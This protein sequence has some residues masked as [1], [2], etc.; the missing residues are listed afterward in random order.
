MKCLAIFLFLFVSIMSFGQNQKEIDSLFWLTRSN[1]F[2]SEIQFKEII[3]KSD[4]GL[5]AWENIDVFYEDEFGIMWCLIDDGLYRYNGHSAIN[6]NNYLS[7]FY[8][9]NVGEQAGTIF[10]IGRNNII[11]YGERKGLYKIDLKNRTSQKIV[12]DK[13]L[14][15]PNWRN[16]ILHLKEV[17]NTLYVGTS[18][19]LYLIDINT[20]N[21]LKKYLTD[22]IDIHH[23]NSSHGVVSYL[24]DSKNNTLWVAVQDGL[25]KINT[26]NDSIKRY[27]IKDA[28]YIYPH[29]FHDLLPYEN[30]FL[31]PTHGMG[32][33]EFN[34]E[35]G[36]FSHFLTT[37]KKEY[38]RSPNVIR[39]A[40]PLNDSIFLVNA[41]QLGNGLY[42]RYTKN[43][44][45]IETPE[46][47]KDG[48]FFN[49]DRSGYVWACK[50]G[51]IF[52]STQ[53]LIEQNKAYQHIIDI[54]SFVAN[55]V[56]IGSP[57][58]DNYSAIELKENMRNIS[59][60]FSISKPFILDTISYEYTLNENKWI[61]IETPNKLNLFNLSSGE[62]Q[63]T[64]RA[65]NKGGE[66]LTTRKLNFSIFLPFYKSVYFI[67]SIVLLFLTAIYLLFRYTVH[68]KTAKKL[69]ELNQAKSNFFTNISH[70]F[71]TPLTLISG[72]IQ[73]QLS[74]ET[75][76]PTE[77]ENFQ[78]ANRNS[79]RLLSLVDQLLDISKLEAGN[80]N[81]KVDQQPILP[82]IGSLA[83]SFTYITKEKDITY[84]KYINQTEVTTYFDADVLEK[85]LINLLSN[86]V[87]YTPKGGTV[88][89]NASVNNNELQAIIKNTGKGLNKT[90]Q[91]KIFE[92]FYQINENK[93][94]I[95]I[96]LALVKELVI[97]HKGSIT[98]E[99]TPNEWTTFTVKL[100]I[101]KNAFS[102][103][104]M[105]ELTESKPSEIVVLESELNVT[106]SQEEPNIE[107]PDQP[108]LLIVDDNYDIR[109]YV[110]SIFKNNYTILKAKNGQ[111]GIDLAI[112]HIP[113]IIVS[114]VMMPVKNG[115]ELCNT[116]KNDER[117]SHIPIV[118]LT[119]KAGEENEL[120]GI[121][122]GA[123]DYITKPFHEE[124]LKERIKKRIEIRN[125][126]Q[127]RYSQEVI[128]R[129]KD[130]AITPVDEQF[131]ER[132]QKILDTKLIEPSFSIED[133]S[134]ALGMSR[135]QLHRKLKALTGMSAS[136]FIRSQRL[137][138]AAQL[139]KKSEINVSQV[140]YS[141]GFN[142]HA[143]F[144]KCFKDVYHCTP[145]EYSKKK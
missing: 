42:N 133:F 114:D 97:L 56:L 98:I 24:I 118:L 19:G 94:G 123:D 111:E 4:D 131:L 11:W 54:S 64:I 80:L 46:P 51:R 69:Q 65:I 135:M 9:L 137:K 34:K 140:G 113:D 142:Y 89:C 145:T 22:G 105:S 39:S 37:K 132:M 92:R 7:N 93:E 14:H 13:P 125:K 130:I 25:Y 139:L 68:R 126:L 83:D 128:L 81:L 75:L 18:N 21:V 50:R 58:I 38:S 45:W 144:S 10:F 78:A 107:N 59:L 121:K 61:P 112:E 8:N 104:E 47:M 17:E 84:L 103:E 138:L 26:T 28:P 52:R 129:P 33:I 53:P 32:M 124:L 70:E 35:T 12:L 143:Y 77:R 66:V 120:E 67:G 16:F 110:S 74:K 57:S 71:R 27:Q 141:V 3:I 63:L 41:Q 30:I 99:S 91:V 100:P 86:A 88:I 134:K 119:A 36:D 5:Q 90:E 82:F 108:I 6:I 2:F 115:I 76:T 109:T 116:L 44:V 85:I 23:R 62:K 48:V 31:I 127:L 15:P 136:E 102:K 95:G 117:T 73:Q 96:G 29:N 106:E 20:N 55:N 60:E 72:P 87:K 1:N 40:I 43:Y 122:T 101:N 49:V 79:K